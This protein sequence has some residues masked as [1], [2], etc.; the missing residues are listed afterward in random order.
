[1]SWDLVVGVLTIIYVNFILSG[2]N[3]VVIALAVRSLPSRQQKLGIAWGS[4]FAV[5]LRI[6]L[7]FVAAK[8]LELSGLR[9]AGGLTLVWVTWK[10]VRPGADGGEEEHVRSSA[11]LW[12]AVRVIVVADLIMSLDNVLAVAAAAKGSLALLIFGLGL[13]IPIILCCAAVIATLMNRFPWLVL[14]GG[15]I[16]GKVAGELL[17]TD[18]L[19]LHYIEPMAKTVELVF[20]LA[21]A[22]VIVALARRKQFLA[23]FRAGANG[24]IVK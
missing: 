15:L 2:D 20:P 21:L 19:V 7:T 9:L 13:S 17:V 3:A 10:L 22:V 24:A 23:R 6:I 11:N 4:L 18:P 1:M 8:L 12:E 16:L 5:I 14:L